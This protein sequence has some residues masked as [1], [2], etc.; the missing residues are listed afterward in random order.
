MF[1]LHSIGKRKIEALGDALSVHADSLVNNND[2]YASSLLEQYPDDVSVLEEL[3]KVSYQLHEIM[4]PVRPRSHFV[5]DLKTELQKSQTALVASREKQHQR[6]ATRLIN[7]L[8][9]VLSI[10][11]VT[12]LLT[13][14]IGAIIMLM[15]LRSRRRRS[16]A[17][18]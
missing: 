4:A 13:R 9:T 6:N 5:S 8:G 11:A 2:E 16:V 15:T 17:T 14:L 10:L 12:A 1:I 7:T 3:F 18:V